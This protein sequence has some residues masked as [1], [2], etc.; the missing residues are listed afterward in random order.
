MQIE[1]VD[2]DVLH[3]AQKVFAA[4]ETP[5]NDVPFPNSADRDIEWIAKA[6]M[7]ERIK[8]RKI[9]SESCVCKFENGTCVSSC[10]YHSQC[11]ADGEMCP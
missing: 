1:F 9:L 7:K 11:S 2:P 8:C 4:L 5:Y 6:I 10:D 3:T